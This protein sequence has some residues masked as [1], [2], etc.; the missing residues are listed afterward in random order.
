M[1]SLGNSVR[2][3]EDRRLVTGHG[4]YVSDLELPRMRHVAFLRSPYGHARI[5]GVDASAA[6]EAGYRVFTGA[7]FSDVVLRAQ[8]AL[9]SYVE[10]DQPVIAHEKACFA[11]EPVAAVVA[12]DRYQ[13]ED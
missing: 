1:S 11:G 4:R 2:R 5:T 9:P 3:K 12:L 6:R 13:A 10:T 8:S 7:D